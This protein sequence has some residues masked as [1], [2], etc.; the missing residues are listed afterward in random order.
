MSDEP[1]TA[2]SIEDLIMEYN[3]LDWMSSGD[4]VRRDDQERMQQRMAAILAE[5][6]TRDC[7]WNICGDAARRAAEGASACTK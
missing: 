5:A 6:K 2:M 3:H 7:V 4:T 1:I